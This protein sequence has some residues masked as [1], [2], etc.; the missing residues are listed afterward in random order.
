MEYRMYTQRC[1]TV[2]DG[3]NPATGK[4]S[5]GLP[6]S[7]SCSLAPCPRCARPGLAFLFGP[8]GSSL[9]RGALFYGSGEPWQT[10]PL[11]GRPFSQ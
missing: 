1:K 4:R 2:S 3:Q 6:R 11:L 5:G 7:R 8:N 9:S 10:V